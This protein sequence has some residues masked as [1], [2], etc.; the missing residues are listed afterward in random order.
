MYRYQNERNRNRIIIKCR[1]SI[2]QK[3]ATW[4]AISNSDGI[5]L[6]RSSDMC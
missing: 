2:K 3:S 5:S 1:R 4:N 6:R